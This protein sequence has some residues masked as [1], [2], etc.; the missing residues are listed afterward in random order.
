MTP[1][2]KVKAHFAK[3]AKKINLKYTNLINTG[4]HGDPDKILWI[5][6]GRPILAEFKSDTGKLSQCQSLKKE[7]YEGLGYTY[8]VVVGNEGVDRLMDLATLI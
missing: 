4:D 5:P 7:M 3:A 1:E 2:G 8:L 6:G